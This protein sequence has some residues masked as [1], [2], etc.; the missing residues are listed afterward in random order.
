MLARGFV[1]I[2]LLVFVFIVGGGAV[3]YFYGKD[4]IKEEIMRVY[5]IVAGEDNTE[6]LLAG[7]E[8]W[9]TLNHKP[10]PLI[11]RFPPTWVTQEGTV[12]QYT[13][14]PNVISAR[15]FNIISVIERTDSVYG[16]YL[17]EDL[18]Y[19][20]YG[21][22]KGKRF[23]REYYNPEREFM[24]HIQSGKIASGEK[25]VIFKIKQDDQNYDSLS[26]HRAFILKSSQTLIIMTLSNYDELG[27]N[28]FTK[29]V[30]TA[31][32]RI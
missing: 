7:T 15:T 3:I 28:I 18:F 19:N 25:F 30:A 10:N 11:L 24:E 14:N 2:G 12:S 13:Y 26:N 5:T 27:E 32:L 16:G 4:N 20:V 6:N 22:K 9:P 23:L 29:V 1:L 17:N 31:K 8:D 21:L